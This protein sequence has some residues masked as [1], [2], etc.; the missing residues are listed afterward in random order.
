MN[1]EIMLAAGFGKE[2]DLIDQGKCSTCSAEILTAGH[3]TNC[4]E[5]EHSFRDELSLK[6]YKISGMWQ[7]CQDSFFGVEDI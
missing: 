4:S 3:G 1:R 6:E 7:D 2:L 5:I